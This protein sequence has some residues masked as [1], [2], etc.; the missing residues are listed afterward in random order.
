MEIY[1][2]ALTIILETY[3]IIA[4]QG[5]MSSQEDAVAEGHSE[6]SLSPVP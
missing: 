4:A 3:K 2:K 1:V 6:H 5:R